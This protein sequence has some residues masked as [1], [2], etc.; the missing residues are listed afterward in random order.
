MPLLLLIAVE[1][2]PPNALPP[3][4]VFEAPNPVFVFVVGNILPDVLVPKA[5]P[6]PPPPK[7]EPPEFVAPNEVVAGLFWPKS[8]I[9]M[10]AGRP[11]LYV[12]YSLRDST[13]DGTSFTSRAIKMDG[14][15]VKRAQAPEKVIILLWQFLTSTRIGA[16]SCAGAG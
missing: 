13:F 2:K 11:S 3:E 10:L 8:P 6:V 1:P 7:R 12:T 16:K 9:Q 15:R 14:S 5:P 4:F